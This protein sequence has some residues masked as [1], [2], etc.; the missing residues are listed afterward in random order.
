VSGVAGTNIHG[1]EP[2]EDLELVR[3]QLD[4]LAGM[5][6]EGTLGPELDQ[7]YEALCAR[8]QELLGPEAASA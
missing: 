1:V 4:C 2:S 6:L 7:A 8:E 3:R 5:R